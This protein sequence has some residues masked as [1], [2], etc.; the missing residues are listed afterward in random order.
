MA[1]N[2]A[3]SKSVGA[4]SINRSS[5]LDIR[6]FPRLIGRSSQVC[7]SPQALISNL[8]IPDWKTGFLPPVFLGS[9][10]KKLFHEMHQHLKDKRARLSLRP[11]EYLIPLVW[12]VGCFWP[13]KLSWKARYWGMDCRA[14]LMTNHMSAK[15]FGF[16]KHGAVCNAYVSF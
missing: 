1:N 4:S 14:F 10:K 7:D 16:V 9:K 11:G 3:L 15:I 6:A 8:C 12:L 13:N 2:L 5:F